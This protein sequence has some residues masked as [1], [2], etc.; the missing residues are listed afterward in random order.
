LYALATYLHK[1][2]LLNNVFD[3]YDDIVDKACEAWF[4]FA[5]GKTTVTTI[6]ARG[7]IMASS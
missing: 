4:F 2:N 5:N 7:W 6:A 3:S 1:N